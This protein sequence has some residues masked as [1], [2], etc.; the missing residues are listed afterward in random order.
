MRIASLHMKDRY[1]KQ[2]NRTFEE[3]TRLMEQSDGDKIHRPS[4]DAVGYSKFLRYSGSLTE[5]TQYQTN[6][7]TAVS[8][9]KNSDA[10]L[11]DM[12]KCFST[13][14]EKSNAAQG[15]NT[16]SDMKAIA[17][18]MKVM[19]QHAVSD[20]N[21]QVD[22]RYLFSGQS[23][24]VQPYTMSEKKFERGLSKT[25][26][27]KQTAFF[28]SGTGDSKTASS[29]GMAQMLA[30]KGDDG[31]SY[32][33]NTVTGKVYAK[34]FMDQGYKD[35]IA[36]GQTTVQA[37][38]EVGTLAGWTNVAARFE[39]T[40]VLKN[41]PGA[42]AGA[43]GGVNMTFETVS[44]NIVTYQGDRK[45][46]SMVKEN[47]AEQ[48]ASDEVNV[49]GE[50]IMGTSIFDD[51]SSGNRSSGAAAFNDLLTVVAKAE[52]G[53]SSWQSSDG[54]T[55]A[56]NAFNIVNN[57]E[58]KLAARQQVYTSCQDMLTTMN[59]SITSDITDVHSADIAKLAVDLMQA[60]TIYN[61]SLSVGSR[62]L[63]PT[64]AD[65]LS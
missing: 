62:I 17:G 39:N 1:L 9:M 58:S 59:E 4:D 56:N 7:K 32:Y 47:G 19:V 38:D 65:Y 50:D 30:L 53:D 2:L 63:P 36:S 3:K 10:A 61:L 16:L 33:L 52:Q 6:V 27:D 8:W 20:A 15:T 13:I 24:L 49:N 46:F 22:G 40:G 29:G 41:P 14:V 37:G 42:A 25:L 60:Q 45:H 64:L 44:Q 57:A 43:V 23:D 5:N 54:K 26:D 48:P 35:K 28:N 51:P 18:E 21:T 11:A 12:T 34:E 55:L 31:N